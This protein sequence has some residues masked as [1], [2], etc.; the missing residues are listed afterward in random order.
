MDDIVILGGLILLI[1]ILLTVAWFIECTYGLI[2]EICT[3][4]TKLLLKIAA[5]G[6]K[7]K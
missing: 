2:S 7:E 5:I 6:K 4:P 3:M 1:S